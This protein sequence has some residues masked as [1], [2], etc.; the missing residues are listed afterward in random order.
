MSNAKTEFLDRA[1]DLE[2]TDDV[3]D[4]YG[5]WARSYDANIVEDNGYVTPQRSAEALAR[6]ARPEGAVLDI[7]CGTGLSGLALTQAGFTTV[8]GFD[9]S[10]EM[11]QEARAKG[12]YRDLKTADITQDLPYLPA[13]YAALNACG[14][15]GHQ[16]T[17]PER[18]TVLMELLKPGHCFSFSLNDHTYE[19]MDHAYPKMID[20]LAE[21]GKIVLLE[22]EYGAHL[23][24]IDLGAWVYVIEKTA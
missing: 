23:P 1:Y 3:K 6:R 18:F 13:S 14:V 8:D 12:V 5:D 22:K 17:P 11:L 16:H 10:E 21:T 15:F 9:L 19:H 2:S 7:G 24:G 4:F 20:G